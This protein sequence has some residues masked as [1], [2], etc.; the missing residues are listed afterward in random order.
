MSRASKYPG[1]VS[2]TMPVLRK[3]GIS[4]DC[5]IYSNIFP[6]PIIINKAVS[7]KTKMDKKRNFFRDLIRRGLVILDFG[8]SIFSDRFKFLLHF[9]I[10]AF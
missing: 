9:Q 10:K 4:F 1:A 2:L 7:V 8:N 6:R 3:S 5:T